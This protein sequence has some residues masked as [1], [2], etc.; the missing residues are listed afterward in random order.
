MQVTST[1]RFHFPAGRCTRSH[2]KV[3]SRLDCRQRQ[4]R[5]RRR[6]SFDFIGENEWPSNST[7]VNPL[8]YHVCLKLCLNI[9]RHSKT[10]NAHGLKKV[11]QIIWDHLPQDS[12]QKGHNG[13]LYKRHRTYVK[14][15][16]D[17]TFRTCFEKK[18]CLMTLNVRYKW[19]SNVHFFGVISK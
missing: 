1:V 5:R 10:E 19:L 12:N 4:W 6:N 18:N 17:I 8:D 13:E 16:M 7:G 9:T 11:L 3:G 15:G 14:G 2:G